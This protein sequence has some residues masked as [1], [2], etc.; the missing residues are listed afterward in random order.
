M[1]S[2]IAF[3]IEGPRIAK[4][5]RQPQLSFQVNSFSINSVRGRLNIVW[6]G[7]GRINCSPYPDRLK[8]LSAID[9]D[10]LSFH[11]ETFA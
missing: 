7:F 4:I 11:I 3:V 1:T 2:K 10:G 5:V 6:S 9:L 8:K